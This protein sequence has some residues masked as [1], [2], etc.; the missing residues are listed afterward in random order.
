MLYIG[1]DMQDR[2]NLLGLTVEDVASRTFL[3]KDDVDAIIHD[4]IGLPDIDEFDFSLIC[5]V[6]HCKPEYFTDKTVKDSDLLA[7]SMNRG[8]DNE[9]SLNVKAKLQDYLDDLSFVNEI[10]LEVD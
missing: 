2:M 6:L 8:S 5:S 4:R 1:N 7:V 3:E 10:L 9:K